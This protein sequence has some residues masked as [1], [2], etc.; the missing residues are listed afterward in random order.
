MISGQVRRG[1]R[2]GALLLATVVAV[3]LAVCAMHA[4][5]SHQ[6]I[7][8]GQAAS[9]LIDAGNTPRHAH[10]DV[11]PGNTTRTLDNPGDPPC[12]HRGAGEICLALL[13][14]VAAR[15]ALALRRGV[16]DRVL[17]VLR[18]WAAPA[19]RW[20]SRIGDPPCLHRLSVLR[21]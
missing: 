12:D 9:A 14:I 2:T 20:I 8:G 11:A 15:L 21:C 18:R 3:V 16:S 5:T 19:H 13:C 6:Q 17:Y 10:S 1:H 7:H 4:L